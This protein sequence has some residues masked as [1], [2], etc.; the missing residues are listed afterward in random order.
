MNVYYKVAVMTNRQ[1][2][3][4]SE[5]KQQQKLKYNR[6]LSLARRKQQ[7]KLKLKEKRNYSFF[8]LSARDCLLFFLENCIHTEPEAGVTWQAESIYE[9]E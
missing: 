3:C 6:L 9:K 4:I 2:D 8:L 1:V 7:K 5:H